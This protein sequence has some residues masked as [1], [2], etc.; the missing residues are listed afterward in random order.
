MTYLR[1]LGRHTHWLPADHRTDRPVLG[2][3]AGARGS[4]IVDAGNSPAHAELLLGEV[5]RLGLAPPMLLMLTHWHW[6]HVFGAERLGL[7]GLAHGETRRIVAALAELPWDDAALDARVAA[8]TEIAFCRDMIRA[9]LPDRAGLRIRPPEV[10][11]SDE[12]SVD[13]GGLVCRL[14]HVGGDHS[15]DSSIVYVPSEGVAFLG[16]CIYDDL[17]HGPRRLTV[18]KILPLLERL[19]A[20]GA[21]HYLSAHHAEPLTRAELAAE[22]AMIGTI[23]RA[24]EAVG[25]DRAALLGL[26]PGLLGKPLDEDHIEVAEAFLAGLRLPAVASVL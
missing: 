18:G 16:D 8:G 5:A 19:L 9:E 24:A 1:T 14:I 25:D 23:A 7:P 15:P 11:F 22:A 21:E 20:L 10:A 4:L 12:L 2:V 26:L 3:I 13:L 17:H 6:D